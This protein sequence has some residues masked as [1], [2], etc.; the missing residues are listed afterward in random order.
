M[1]KRLII[2]KKPMYGN[3]KVYHPKGHLMFYCSKKKYN[4]Y[5]KRDLAIVLEGEEKSIQLT[6]NPKGDG[7]KPRFL[8]SERQNR[9]VECGT[10]EDLTKHHVVPTRYRKHFPDIYKSKNSN[11]VVVMCEEDHSKYE[12]VA[13]KF[14]YQLENEY[15]TE[16][17]MEYNK[18]V[19]FIYKTMNTLEKHEDKIPEE[20]LNYLREK[21]NGYME[22]L[23]I[24][25]QEAKDLELINFNKL[26]VERCGI[27]KLIVDWKNHFIKNT[28]VKYLPDWWDPNYVK[29]VDFR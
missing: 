18:M 25:I 24:V 7:E 14:K 28:D 21:M 4:W 10:D 6:F 11:D 12:R 1:S 8:Q 13:D 20:R 17:E 3:Y 23:D 26:I 29:I 2:S 27:E 9:C 22:K 5:L 19:E 15:I 16:E